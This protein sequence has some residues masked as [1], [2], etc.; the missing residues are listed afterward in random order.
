MRD[1]LN[2]EMQKAFASCASLQ[3]LK[4]E[5]PKT[6]EDSIVATQV[7]VQKTSMRT[8]E[9]TAELIRQNI[10][11]IISEA[12][13]QIRVV[14]STGSAEAYRIKQYAV[15]HAINNTITAESDVYKSLEDE[16]GINAADLPEYLFLGAVND[17]KKAKLLVGL[18]N[19]IINLSNQPI[20]NEK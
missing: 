15:A 6:Y 11:V 4:I 5:L 12:D 14:N 1:S 17:Q 18:Q 19:S 2:V 13:Q 7:E 20:T 3:I 10:S 8:Y 16:V 9:Q